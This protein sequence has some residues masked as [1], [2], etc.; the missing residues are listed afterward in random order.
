MSIK[1]LAGLVSG[2]LLSSSVLSATVYVSD[3]QFVAIRE[4]QSNNTRAVERGLKSGT[5]L[6]VLEQQNGHTKVR[7]PDGN[8]GWVADYFLS[9]TA[10]TRDQILAL[11]EQL[12]RANESK[13]DAQDALANNQSQLQE[14]SR[15]ISDLEAQNL[16]LQENLAESKEI[17]AKAQIIVEQNDNI[18]YQLESLKTQA[19]TAQ[20]T[21]LKLQNSTNQKWFMIGAATLFL[22]FIMGVIIP[23]SR[24][25]KV[26][27][28]SW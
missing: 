6:E 7:T 10:V 24:R 23:M 17:T 4:G 14:L 3:I 1:H 11:Q 8:E 25:K 12:T 2:L 16:S 9:D 22:G 15:T 5:P 19:E 21:M 27:T 18:S 28:S 20:Q 26:N 13:V